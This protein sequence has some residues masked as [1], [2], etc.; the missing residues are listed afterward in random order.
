M[1]LLTKVGSFAKIDTTGTQAITGVGFTPKAIVFWTSGSNAASGTWDPHILQSIGFTAGPTNSYAVGLAMRDGVGDTNTARRMAAKVIC[2][3]HYDGTSV[4]EEA[5]LSSFDADG[6]TLNWTTNAA[7]PERDGMVFNYLALGGS[8]L[9]GAKVVQWASPVAIGNQAVTGVGFK[10]DV[11]LH[12][13]PVYATSNALPL[14]SS[15]VYE[16][17]GAMNK[18]GQQWASGLFSYDGQAAANTTRYQQ[19]D[20]CLIVPTSNE[21]VLLQGHFS[22]IDAD[23][24]TTYWSTVQTTAY[25]IFSLCLQGVSSKLGAFEKTTAAAPATQVVERVGFT[26]KAA[27]FTTKRGGALA[28][29]E[30]HAIRALGASDGTNERATGQIDFDTA[31]P[32]QADA[33]WSNTKA[34]LDVTGGPSVGAEADLT[35]FDSDGFTLNWTTND[36]IA[37]EILYLALGDA[38]SNSTPNHVYLAGEPAATSQGGSRNVVTAKNGNRVALIHHGSGYDLVYSTDGRTWQSVGTGPKDARPLHAALFMDESDYLHM[39][40]KQ[41]AA[42]GNL[43]L[44]K[45]YYARGTPNADRTS[46]TWSGN[47]GPFS[48]AN[49]QHPDLVVFRDGSGGWAVHIV[50]AENDTANT[51]ALH[52][53]F[54]IFPDGTLGTQTQTTIGGNYS[55]GNSTLPSIDFNHIGDGKTVKDGTP[56]IYVCWQAGQT[57]AGKG[58]RFRKAT[59]TPVKTSNGST[60]ADQRTGDGQAVFTLPDA[61]TVTFAYTGAVQTYTVPSG[62]NKITVE[63]WGAE[64]ATGSVAT[65]KG[66]YAKADLEVTPG[67]TLDVY[68]GGK[69][70]GGNGGYNGGGSTP[71]GY[72]GGGA[73]DVRQGGTALANRVIVAAGGG[74]PGAGGSAGSGGAGGGYYGT[75]GGNALNTGGYNGGGGSQTAGGNGGAGG[76]VAGSL[77]AGGGGGDQG[78]GGGGGYYGGGGGGDAGASYDGS[79]GGGGSSFIMA[80]TWTWEPEREIDTSRYVPTDGNYFIYTLFDGTRVLMAALTHTGTSIDLIL[81]ERDAADTAT[82][83]RAVATGMS[84]AD[85]LYRGAATHDANQDVHFF[86]VKYEG[87]LFRDLRYRK[88]SRSSGVLSPSVVLDSGIT[89]GYVSPKRG[90]GD[91]LVEVIY[92]FGNQSLYPVKYEAIELPSGNPMR[93]LV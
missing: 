78:G 29:P 30:Q 52:Q 1:A 8:D 28:G 17:F 67:E 16:G 69:P 73:T 65:G 62:V 71:G 68:V 88:W 34:I 7:H 41:E 81:H 79:G 27:L 37:S 14:S 54:R 3:A 19:T 63:C 72:G 48:G 77:G 32:T 51:F 2:T 20:A 6:F 10:P 56:H 46:W 40:W 53:F 25:H 87:S 80:P 39:V 13:S 36:T 38:G 90:H 58:M 64:G 76:G 59:F 57:G 85:A 23:G 11:V 60:T 31:D 82:T 49:A 93:M 47:K 4:F 75:S 18:H 44:N 42:V 61:T 33:I 55:N 92:T 50:H 89:Q 91:G 5:D 84:D 21:G 83:L 15:Y 43:T 26:P 70:T 74:G 66:G 24:F 45:I 35:S 86:G 22:S 12:I 9:T